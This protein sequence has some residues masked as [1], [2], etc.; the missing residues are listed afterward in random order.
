MLIKIFSSWWV[1]HLTD[2]FIFSLSLL[3]MRANFTSCH[4]F[5]NMEEVI[6]ESNASTLDT[7]GIN[8]ISIGINDQLWWYRIWYQMLRLVINHFLYSSWLKWNQSSFCHNSSLLLTLVKI[9]FARYK[10][11]FIQLMIDMSWPIDIKSYA[12]ALL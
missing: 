10:I 2:A 4:C 12:K 11:P 5:L 6:F 8:D 9:F 3:L 1:M 7:F